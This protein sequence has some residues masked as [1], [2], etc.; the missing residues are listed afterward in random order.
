MC[1]Y[2]R[3]IP[4][5]AVNLVPFNLQKAQPSFAQYDATFNQLGQMS[6]TQATHGYVPPSTPIMNPFC[7]TG[8][9]QTPTDGAYLQWPSAAMMYAHSYDQFRHAVFQV[10]NI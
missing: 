8:L 5:S 9:N 10:N 1:R 2:A 3:S 4:T 7:T 6:Q